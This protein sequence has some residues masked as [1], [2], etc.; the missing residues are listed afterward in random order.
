MDGS[1]PSLNF[2]HS[3]SFCLHRCL[4]HGC[5]QRQASRQL[6]NTAAASLTQ[7]NAGAAR[8]SEKPPRDLFKC[9]RSSPEEPDEFKASARRFIS[10]ADTSSLWVAICQYGMTHKSP[11]VGHEIRLISHRGPPV[12]PIKEVTGGIRTQ[13]FGLGRDTDSPQV[14]PIG[15]PTRLEGDIPIS[16]S[17]RME[18]AGFKQ[19]LKIGV[20]EVNQRPAQRPGVVRPA[21]AVTEI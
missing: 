18:P 17:V 5:H 20:I 16:Q 9:G 4:G 13:E 11:N 3:N 1:Y 8:I 12:S 6:S 7:S 21:E 14:K 10:S 2:H 15:V 19:Q